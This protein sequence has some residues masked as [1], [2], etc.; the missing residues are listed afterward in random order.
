MPVNVQGLRD[1]ASGLSQ[2]PGRTTIE[3]QDRQDTADAGTWGA[4]HFRGLLVQAAASAR[5][6]TGYTFLEP[7]ACCGFLTQGA[8]AG[9]THMDPELTVTSPPVT[10]GHTDRET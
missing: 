10:G 4:L 2:A 1:Q 8:F 5:V 7:S 6:Y 9:G 3:A